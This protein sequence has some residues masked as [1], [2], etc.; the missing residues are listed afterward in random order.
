MIITEEK[1]RD[2]D[3]N[4]SGEFREYP[5]FFKIFMK[6]G[7]RFKIRISEEEKQILESEGFKFFAT[8]KIIEIHE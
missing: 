8:N 1:V 3:Y 7:E 4:N 2:Y 5:A 6:Q